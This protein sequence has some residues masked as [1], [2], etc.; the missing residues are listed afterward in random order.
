MT[1][2]EAF[3][4]ASEQWGGAGDEADYWD[5]ERQCYTDQMY[6]QVAWQAWQASRK[7]AL[8]EAAKA[9]EALR[10]DHCV[11]TQIDPH[12]E[13]HCYANSPECEFVVA[14]NDAAA[15]IRSLTPTKGQP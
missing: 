14:W 10:D 4:A 11:S 13:F 5:E 3:E 15:A 9:V 8:E 6:T 1:E 12:P 2:R 7:Q